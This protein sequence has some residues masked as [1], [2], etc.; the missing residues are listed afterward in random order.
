MKVNWR[1]AFQPKSQVQRTLDAHYGALKNT[2]YGIAPYTSKLA[3]AY[4]LLMIACSQ[5]RQNT[6]AQKL[7]D[8]DDSRILPQLI[9]QASRFGTNYNEAIVDLNGALQELQDHEIGVHELLENEVTMGVDAARAAWVAKD[10]AQQKFVN[11]AKNP[12]LLTVMDKMVRS[13]KEGRV[14]KNAYDAELTLAIDNIE[15]RVGDHYH[16]GS[17]R[18]VLRAL[19]DIKT[20]T[21][22]LR[23][24]MSTSDMER[25]VEITRNLPRSGLKH[26]A[27]LWL[28]TAGFC[29]FGGSAAIACSVPGLSSDVRG[30]LMVPAAAGVIC[31]GRGITLRHE[32]AKALNASRELLYSH[33]VSDGPPPSVIR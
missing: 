24:F 22:E 7:M 20:L 33:A 30:G 11:I 23:E 32:Y 13:L 26:N 2:L 15:S 1:T 6:P 10:P 17:L 31:A 16:Y 21:G 19:Q 9:T 5:A 27:A 8:E 14:N 18:P 4:A 25:M 12:H 28:A 29:L 3:D